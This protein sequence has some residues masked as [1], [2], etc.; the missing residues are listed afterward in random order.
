MARSSELRIQDMLESIALVEEL[1][2]G[3]AFEDYRGS[4]ASRFA[5]ERAIEIISE[6]SR[7]LPEAMKL[8]HPEIRWADIAG[9]GNILR[10]DYQRVDPLLMW[11]VFEDHL[12]ALKVAL[13]SML[14]RLRAT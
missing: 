2:A 6:A 4:M 13:L 3:K 9:I 1:T 7:S 14:G 8:L 10:H 11:R 5:A 12:P